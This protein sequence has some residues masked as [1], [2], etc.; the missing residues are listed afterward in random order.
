M[1]YKRIEILLNKFWACETTLE[2]EMEL[3]RFFNECQEI[4]SHLSVFRDVFVWQKE[5]QEVALDNSFDERILAKVKHRGYNMPRIKKYFIRI[6]AC[7]VL[8]ISIAGIYRYKGEYF[9]RQADGGGEMTAQQALAEVEKALS[10]VSAKL[11]EG[12]Q[13]VE[14]NM[15]TVNVATKY[16]K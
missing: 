5:E 7:C 9:T 3:R 10:Y 6:A 2:E 12:G 13:L 8:L 11:N 14:D 16:I 1:D 4:P 15:K